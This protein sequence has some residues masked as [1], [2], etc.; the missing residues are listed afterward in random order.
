MDEGD[1]EG[2]AVD[3]G[4]PDRQMPDWLAGVSRLNPLTLA[5]D[6][7]RDALLS[8]TMPSISASLLPLAV[9]A[10]ALFAVALA[11]MNRVGVQRAG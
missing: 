9:L 10:A 4:V 11:A 5:V 2:A 1:V 3:L 6:A 7:W 8:G